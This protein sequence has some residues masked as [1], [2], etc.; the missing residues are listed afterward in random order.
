MTDLTPVSSCARWHPGQPS[1][2][3]RCLPHTEPRTKLSV[4]VFWTAV[5]VI[6]AILGSLHAAWWQ[7]GLA[8]GSVWLVRITARREVV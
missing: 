3:L 1:Q 8:F 7:T 4:I 6:L 2:I 5:L